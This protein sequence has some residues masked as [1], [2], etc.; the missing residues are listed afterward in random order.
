MEGPWWSKVVD[1]YDVC[2]FGYHAAGCYGGKVSKLV[3]TCVVFNY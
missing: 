1:K 2:L 3:L